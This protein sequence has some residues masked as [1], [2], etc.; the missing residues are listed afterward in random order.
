MV[1]IFGVIPVLVLGKRKEGW[2]LRGVGE[3]RER[4]KQGLVLIDGSR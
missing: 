2:V 4:D 3:E 1:V